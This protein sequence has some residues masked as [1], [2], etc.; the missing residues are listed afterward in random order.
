MGID[1]GAVKAGMDDFL[2]EIGTGAIDVDVLLA[3]PAAM[4]KLAK[5][6][7]ILGP[8]GLMPS[9]KAGTV[10]SNVAESVKEFMAGKVDLRT[11]KQGNIHVPIGKASFKTGDLDENLIAVITAVEKNRPSGAK[12]KYWVSG[13]V[14]STMGPAVKL[15]LNAIKAAIE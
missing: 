4:P 9:P 11:D 6:G 12:G 3:V 1:A 8:K 15:D 5:F 7:K 14:C 2:E 10:T 13:T